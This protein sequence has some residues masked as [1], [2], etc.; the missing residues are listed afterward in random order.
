MRSLSRPSPHARPLLSFP[1]A[2]FVTQFGSLFGAENVFYKAPL[3]VSGPCPDCNAENRAFFG[4]VLGIEGYDPE[5]AKLKC[6]NCGV[7]LELK[8][9]TL[10]VSSPAKK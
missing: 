6:Q 4:S 9:S 7:A 5:K 2:R 10:R 1:L 8:R 3:V